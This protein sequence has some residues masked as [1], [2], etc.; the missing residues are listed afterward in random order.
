MDGCFGT[1]LVYIIR[2]ILAK[3][4][5][6]KWMIVDTPKKD[7]FSLCFGKFVIEKEISKIQ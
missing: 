5:P 4:I 1:S 6:L 3:L 2:L 7:L